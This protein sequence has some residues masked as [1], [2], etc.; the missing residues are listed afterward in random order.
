MR[1]RNVKIT[2]RHVPSV[3]V[4]HSAILDQNTK[5]VPMVESCIFLSFL[6]HGKAIIGAR[7]GWKHCQQYKLFPL[8]FK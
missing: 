4:L 8:S 3:T 7:A 6:Q 1:A 5:G 2:K